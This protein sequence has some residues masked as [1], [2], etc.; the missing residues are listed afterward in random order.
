MNV[1]AIGIYGFCAV[2][3]AM[4]FAAFYFSKRIAA[5]KVP[6]QWGFDGQPTWYAPKWV[7]L[8]APILVTMLGVPLFLTGIGFAF[9]P[10][11]AERSV[12]GLIVFAVVMGAT[13]GAY[14]FAV[15][16]WASKQPT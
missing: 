12:I 2:V 16:R 5:Q 11:G 10:A 1:I 4:G 3:G 15:M 9:P 13:Y 6:M 7:A 8:Y 14:L